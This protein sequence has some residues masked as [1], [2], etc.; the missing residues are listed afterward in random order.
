MI[1]N[2]YYRWMMKIVERA[3]NRSLD[4]ETYVELHHV[5]PRSLGG[6][7]GECVR[8]TGREHYVV[9]RLLVKC[10]EGEEQ[11]KMIH[12]LFFMSARKKQRRLTSRQ[13]DYIRKLASD[14]YKVTQKGAKNGFYGKTHTE[15][16]K[17]KLSEGKTGERH[18]FYGKKRPDHALMMSKKLKGVPKT[19]EHRDAI[20]RSWKRE[21][22]ECNHCGKRTTRAMNTRWHGNNCAMRVN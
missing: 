7:K 17:R 5:I 19:E 4:T 9:H 18:P 8:L 15:E 1:Q 22:V 14:T 13:Y 10:T 6:S 12:A 20:K 11:L 16:V 21:Y 2:K 3:R